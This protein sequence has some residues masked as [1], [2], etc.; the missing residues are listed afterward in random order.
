MGDITFDQNGTGDLHVTLMTAATG[1]IVVTADDNVMT[2][3]VR[4]TVDGDIRILADDGNLTVMDSGI[5]AAGSEG[6]VILTATGED[7]EISINAAV[8]T[9]S[10]A[11]TITATDDVNLNAALTV[12]GGDETV[13]V[14]SGDDIFAYSNINNRAGIVNLTAVE[15]IVQNGSIGSSGAAVALVNLDAGGAIIDTTSEAS[16]IWAVRLDILGATSVGADTDGNPLTWVDNN[17]LDTQVDVLNASGVTGSMFIREADDIELGAVNAALLYT[18]HLAV[19]AGNITL[20]AVDAAAGT[21]TLLATGAIE[22]ADGAAI[23]VNS[24]RYG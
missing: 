19:H 10:G 1:D 18:D 8:T 9:A 21:V 5:S 2:H 3:D 4:T 22:D 20:G 23:G 7:E 15:D 11:I 14:T 16:R 12:T 13:T 6:E 17:W 24:S